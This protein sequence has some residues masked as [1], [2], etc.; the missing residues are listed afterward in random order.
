MRPNSM[1]S[2]FSSMTSP[3]FAPGFCSWT[4]STVISVAGSW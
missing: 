3:T 4:S 2:I 1:D